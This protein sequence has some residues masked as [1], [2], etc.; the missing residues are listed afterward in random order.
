M[1]MVVLKGW[2]CYKDAVIT[3]LR[4]VDYHLFM[5]FI[6]IDILTIITF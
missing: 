3:I 4:K 6:V 2:N 1:R 5:A